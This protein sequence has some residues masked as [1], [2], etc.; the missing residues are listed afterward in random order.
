MPYQFQGQHKNE[1]VVLF[2]RQH[3]F[4]LLKPLFSSALIFLVPFIA[5]IF[6]PLGTVVSWI[7]IGSLIAGLFNAWRAWHAWHNSLVLLTNERVI[8]M[9][10]EHVLSREFAECNLENIQQV[11]HQIKG[12]LPTIMKYGDLSIY[13]AGSQHAFMVP[14]LPDPYEVQQEILRL[15]S[16]E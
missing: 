4:V 5:Y 11:T 14:N 12:L 7:I 8:I 16:E 15:V 9:E 6:L 13:T 1:Q 3:P 2:S 10:Q